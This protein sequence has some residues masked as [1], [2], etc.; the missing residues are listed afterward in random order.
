MAGWMAV[1][2]SVLVV[3]SV[4]ETISGL[5]TIETRNAVEEFLAEDGGRALGL[6][7]PGALSA[8]RVLSMVA[9][10]CAAAAAI[11]AFHVLRGNNGARIGLTVVAVPLFFTGLVVGGFL[12]SLVAASAVVLW[13]APSRAWF[14][15]EQPPAPRE[16]PQAPPPAVAPARSDAGGPDAGA[17]AP[18]V[19]CPDSLVWACVLTWVLCALAAL[20]T[21]V[22]AWIVAAN[23]EL[24]ARELERQ[25]LDRGLSQ[26]TLEVSTQVTAGVSVVWSLLASGLAVLTYRRVPWARVAL[27]VSAAVAGLACL[28]AAFGSVLLVLP[29]AGCGVTVSL[30]LRPEVRAWFRDGR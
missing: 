2:G 10:G 15:G 28:A 7:V 8:L 6:D 17:P 11:L 3:A 24:I 20:V 29:A 30:L 13:T 25:D 21:L 5:N 4:F 22:A 27:L 18:P 19:D 12:S 16:R 9:A 23:P 1:V 14:R 26:R